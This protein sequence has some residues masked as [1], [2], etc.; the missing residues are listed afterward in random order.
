ML[1]MITYDRLETTDHISGSTKKIVG[2]I[3]R[4]SFSLHVVR[5]LCLY[6][7]GQSEATTVVNAVVRLEYQS[8]KCVIVN[9][10]EGARTLATALRWYQK[11][12]SG[13]GTAEWA[14]D[15]IRIA[16]RAGRQHLISRCLDDGIVLYS[17]DFSNVTNERKGMW[18][19]ITGGAITVPDCGSIDLEG[20]S[21]QAAFFNKSGSR[22]IRTEPLD[23]RK[24]RY[25]FRSCL[26]C[27]QRCDA[28]VG[29]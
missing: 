29:H 19:E 11:S 2:V 4:L 5:L 17:S 28:L 25:V 14:I 9:L 15:K 10:P 6:L 23:L 1:S 18:D 3:G 27:F 24:A 26:D 21:S 13:G 8:P 16:D 20:F 12:H 7:L 22:G